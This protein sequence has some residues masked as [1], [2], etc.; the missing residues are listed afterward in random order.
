M[1]KDSKGK[2][3]VRSDQAVRLFEA[4]DKF[5]RLYDFTH[6]APAIR[7]GWEEI[8]SVMEDIREL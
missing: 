8:V 3:W 6:A 4:V 5:E 2:Q 7:E 1:A